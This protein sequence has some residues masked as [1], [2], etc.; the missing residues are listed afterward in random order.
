MEQITAQVDQPQGFMQLLLLGDQL[1]KHPF[2]L[3]QPVGQMADGEGGEALV[4]GA[5]GSTRLGAGGDAQLGE[6][7]QGLG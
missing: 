7:G 2:P 4:I 1:I 6:Q 5:Q 3:N